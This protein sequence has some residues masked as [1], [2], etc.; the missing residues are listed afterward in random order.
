MRDESQI[1]EYRVRRYSAAGCD[2]CEDNVAIEEPLDIRISYAFKSVRR[3]ESA[4]VTMRTPGHEKELAAGLLLA[5]GV[6]TGRS[7]IVD[8]RALGNNRNE[9]LVELADAVDVDEWHLRRATV[10]NSA[11]GLCGKRTLEAMPDM[12]PV[13]A[14]RGHVNT[15]LLYRLPSLF[16]DRQTGFAASGGLHAATLVSANGELEAVFEDIGR[17][18]ALDKLIGYCLFNNLLPLA[19]SVLFMS[20][21]GSF[22]LVQKALAAGCGVLATI[23]APSSLA[24]EY[25]RERMITLIGFVRDDHFNVYSGEWRVMEPAPPEGSKS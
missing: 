5:E 12:Q 14:D 21:R 11:C 8:V 3:V 9:I 25:A 16:R 19:D 22:E 20:S 24:I 1:A 6:I 13:A 18:N 17:H 4:A 2:R 15:G 23:G 7:D 10:L